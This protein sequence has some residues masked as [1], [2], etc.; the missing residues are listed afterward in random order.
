[1]GLSGYVRTNGATVSAG[2]ISPEKFTDETRKRGKLWT[3]SGLRRI[4]K[5]QD[6]PERSD[7]VAEFDEDAEA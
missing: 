6:M 4:I 1:M 5:W 7:I 3:K 2:S